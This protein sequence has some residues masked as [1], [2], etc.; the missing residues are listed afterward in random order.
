[1]DDDSLAD[2]MEDAL[3]YPRNFR[4]ANMLPESAYP[5][6][7]M[8]SYSDHES[9]SINQSEYA[10]DESVALLRLR[11]LYP[12]VNPDMYPL[13]RFWNPTD[14][15]KLLLLSGDYLKVKYAGKNSTLKDAAA[16]RA[17]AP[18][19]RLC[20]IFYFE[21]RV[22]NMSNSACFGIGIGDR[23]TSL[24][25]IPGFESGSYGYHADRGRLVNGLNKIDTSEPYK[26]DDV[27]GCGINFINRTI[28]FTRNGHKLPD[29]FCDVCTTKPYF[30]IVGMQCPGEVVDTNF[31]Q[32]P[33]LFNIE[34]EVQKCKEETLSV[35]E[36]MHLPH[37]KSRWTSRAISD[38][39]A[40][41]GFTTTLTAF[42][43]VNGLPQPTDTAFMKERKRILDLV[44]KG[45]VSEAI[46]SAER[47]APNIFEN[48]VELGM[49]LKIQ[50][51]IEALTARFNDRNEM[52]NMAEDKPTTSNHTPRNK[53]SAP[54]GESSQ[55]QP[56]RRLSAARTERMERYHENNNDN[57]DEEM[58]DGQ[59]TNG[60]S[61]SNGASFNST[62]GNAAST[63]IIAEMDTQSSS[64]S[65][66]NV[67][68]MRDDTEEVKRDVSHNG[69]MNNILELGREVQRKAQ[70][71][72]LPKGLTD[73]MN[74]VFGVVCYVNAPVSPR[75][76]LFNKKYRYH[77]AKYLN[78]AML[79]HYKHPVAEQAG[80]DCICPIERL[81][82]SFSYIH[83]VAVKK[84]VAST[85]FIN[86][87]EEIDGKSSC[88]VSDL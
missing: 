46:V 55:T 78:R 11:K 83:N 47:V 4:I 18:I 54:D 9:P 33:F 41:R 35:I 77:L 71:L 74:E 30:P 62:N 75:A 26:V 69:E 13:P 15:Y 72:E 51:V 48:N 87:A 86:E 2:E 17:N 22:T 53:R 79:R 10:E 1:M 64:S 59:S 56:K 67:D 44:M 6:Q 42:N 58:S 65:E 61:N 32:K 49:L 31:G 85:I 5:L 16:V 39:L 60:L 68:E 37:E 29:E 19:P 25:K 7:R 21:I 14:K 50:E 70:T 76:Y 34:N 88:P 28:F 8:S 27:V 43:K 84:S 24:N 23:S 73:F 45:R 57:E 81:F 66:L 3:N 82:K 40:I 36:N 12:A 63:N 80:E 38:W 20:G 52:T